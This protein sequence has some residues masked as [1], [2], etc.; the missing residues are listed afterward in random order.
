MQQISIQSPLTRQTGHDVRGIYACIYTIF[1]HALQNL[2]NSTTDINTAAKKGSSPLPTVSKE[3]GRTEKIILET[4]P[5][6]N[7]DDWEHT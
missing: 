6:V 3:W 7:T 1:H 5:V 2:D 4:I